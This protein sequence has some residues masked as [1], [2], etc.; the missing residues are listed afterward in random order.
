MMKIKKHLITRIVGNR[1]ACSL[2]IAIIFL[3]AETGYSADGPSKLRPA[4]LF[5]N[6]RKKEAHDSKIQSQ[7]TS[8]VVTTKQPDP[9]QQNVENEVKRFLNSFGHALDTYDERMSPFAD[10]P[11]L[12]ARYFFLSSPSR[13]DFGYGDNHYHL[14]VIIEDEKDKDSFLSLTVNLDNR[15]GTFV[16]TFERTS[17][18]PPGY[19]LWKMLPRIRELLRKI[20]Q[21]QGFHL[22]DSVLDNPEL[23]KWKMREV[24]GQTI[25][26]IVSETSQGELQ[27]LYR[28]YHFL[29]DS[30]VI[31]WAT[32]KTYADFRQQILPLLGWSRDLS[33]KLQFLQSWS[34]KL[35][36]VNIL[37]LS[38]TAEQKDIDEDARLVR[39][40][41][42]AR[43]EVRL[44]ELTKKKQEK[45]KAQ[46][47]QR[48]REAVGTVID[49][50]NRVSG[51]ELFDAE[52]KKEIAEKVLSWGL[53]KG[54]SVLVVGHSGDDYLPILL[55]MLGLKVSVI[56]IDASEAE[57]QE[58][59]H[60]QFGLDKEIESF[61]SYGMLNGKQF[62]YITVL[63][64]INDAIDIL[65]KDDKRA[66]Q[67]F[68]A[69]KRLIKDE[70]IKEVEALAKRFFEPKVKDFMRPILAHLNPDNGYILVNQPGFVSVELHRENAR[71]SSFVDKLL[72]YL[73]NVL[74]SLGEEMG[75]CFTR[76][77]QMDVDNFTV[78]P[79]WADEPRTGVV[80]HAGKIKNNSKSQLESISGSGIR[81][82]RSCL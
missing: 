65:G 74:P 40:N 3:S 78:H 17:Y 77:L 6:T 10:E 34:T 75:V 76:Q 46:E 56:D 71:I 43:A 1:H 27:S 11:R 62:D 39:E 31:S 41:R 80:Y 32:I 42:R 18:L 29:E 67:I 52:T 23:H 57:K 35:V 14:F 2:L 64:V 5:S 44:R 22:V 19:F 70:Q 13:N 55:A 72:V 82:P 69:R 15:E 30:K 79:T 50:I 61:G 63:A 51:K 20:S 8:A 53:V 28:R 68:I 45:A 36:Q 25:E 58:K 73:D 33:K 81:A 24:I 47:A 37:P 7:S 48:Q 54:R 12:K 66:E 21:E 16:I 38:A 26:A 9:P 60:G 59:L 4:L 49:E